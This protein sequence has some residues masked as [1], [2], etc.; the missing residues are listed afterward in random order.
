MAKEIY[1]KEEVLKLLKD[2]MDF[3]FQ[4]HVTAREMLNKNKDDAFIQAMNDSSTGAYAALE[5]L[6][7]DVLNA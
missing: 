5:D 6:Y 3:C 2:E 1:T 7:A 4:Q